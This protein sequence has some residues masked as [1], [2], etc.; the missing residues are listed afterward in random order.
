[1][2]L[3]YNY[4]DTRIQLKQDTQDNWDNVNEVA[5]DGEIIIYAPDATHQYARL[6]V[7][8]G[9]TYIKNLP[10]IDAGTVNGKIIEEV[11]KSFFDI[12]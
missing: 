12:F 8:D 1:M 11:V 9:T 6:K 7:G 10:F 4:L 3:T 5:L 2:N